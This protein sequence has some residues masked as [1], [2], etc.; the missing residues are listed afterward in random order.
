MNGSPDHRGRIPLPVALVTLAVFLGAMKFA[1]FRPYGARAL[2]VMLPVGVVWAGI[3]KLRDA[4]PA[5]RQAGLALGVLVVALAELPVLRLFFGV[6]ALGLE[7]GLVRGAAAALGA[8]SVVLEAVAARRSLRARV[9]AWLGIALGFA[10]Y[11]AGVEIP[12]AERE[13]GLAFV[14]GVIGL[15]GG[16]LAGL[17]LGALGARLAQRPAPATVAPA[18]ALPNGGDKPTAP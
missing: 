6:T 12:S 13:F 9:S 5:L 3:G 10:A 7:P 17:A 1:G 4:H 2:V 16:G 14:A 11:L 8:G 15:W 18:A